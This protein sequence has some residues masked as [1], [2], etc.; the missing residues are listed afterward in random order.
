MTSE[1]T[2][3]T[4][5]QKKPKK[6]GPIRTGVVAPIVIIVAAVW[7]YTTIFLDGHIRRGLEYGASHVYGAEVDIASVRLSFL[8]PSF[9]MTG[10]E[11]T[12]KEQPSQNALAIGNVR[13]ALLWDALLRAKIVIDESSMTEIALY[14]PRKSPGEVYPPPPPPPPEPNKGPSLV[15]KV[16]GELKTEAEA[17]LKNNILGDISKTF[18]G[19]DATEQ[20]K[21]MKEQLQ[22]E[23]KI[24][25]LQASLNTK[26]DE[27]TKRV[28]A[29]PKP[30][31]VKALIEKV[32]ATKINTSNPMEAKSQLEGL[33][34][35]I[36]KVEE[37]VGTFKKGRKDIETDMAGFTT[38]LKQIDDAARKDIDDLQSKLK[39]PKIDAESLTKS[40]LSKIMGD[41]LMKVLGFLDKAKAYMPDKSKKDAGEKNDYVPH[42]RGKGRTYKFPVTVGYPLFWLKKAE[43]SS[44]SSA[45]GFS[46]DLDGRLLNLSSDPAVI[47]KPT[48]FEIKG[49]VPKQQIKDI[50]FGV[51]LDYRGEQGTAKIDLAVASHPFPEQAF[52]KTDDV[53]FMI[54]ATPAV[55]RA[56][57]DFKG[58]E[59][60]AL[61]DESIQNPPFKTD[62]KAPL[63]KE[64]LASITSR[65]K[66]LRMAISLTGSFTNPKFGIDS[67]LGTELA[68][69]FQAHLKAKIEAARAKLKSFVD[70]RIKGE[71][72][73]LTGDL[74]KLQSQFTDAFKGKEGE[75]KN[76]QADLNKAYQDK[77]STGTNKVKDDV[78][79]KAKDALKGFGL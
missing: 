29:L 21:Q 67:N 50:N 18:G 42:P 34:K 53:T 57:A 32:K 25:E 14:S 30:D 79:K 20:L 47:N 77:S 70:D 61:I 40:L 44:K 76:L 27:W 22:S 43:I 15:Q 19:G 33:K 16:G 63:L 5:K 60:N 36:A 23:A 26:K 58:G 4:K 3:D 59:I 49:S 41:K 66:A 62:A 55:L 51:V 46:G 64:A 7:A 48:I 78:Q 65:I 45:G 10:I 8:D 37:T 31:E 74:T 35:D 72:D 68:A 6:V 1:N 71:R 17:Q 28:A 39:L 13:F 75:F 38:G 73:K 2:T 52:A 9:T 54:G 12:D 69:G 24:K 56:H 11:V